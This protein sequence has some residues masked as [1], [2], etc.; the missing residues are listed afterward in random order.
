MVLRGREGRG[1]KGGRGLWGHGGGGVTLMRLLFDTLPTVITA[2]MMS[3]A[4]G[5]DK[6]VI[7]V[8]PRV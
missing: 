3:D 8:G 7:A 5:R 6:L 2:P 1:A 4:Q